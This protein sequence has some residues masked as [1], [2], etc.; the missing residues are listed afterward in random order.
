[1]GASP[2]GQ[3]ASSKYATRESS[4]SGTEVTEMTSITFA[5]ICLFQVESLDPAHIQGEE[6]TQGQE[7]KKVGVLQA[8]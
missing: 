5:V 4:S 7:V 1:M 6:M 8:I 3:L 2:A